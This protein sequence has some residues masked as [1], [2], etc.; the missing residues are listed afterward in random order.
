MVAV[1]AGDDAGAESALKALRASGADGIEKA[2]G[3]W[4]NGDW[5]D[6]DPLATPS[7]VDR[8]GRPRNSR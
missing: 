7:Y 5:A 8:P 2:H 3:E 4:R 6:F 1:N